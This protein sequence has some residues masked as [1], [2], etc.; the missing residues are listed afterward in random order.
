MAGCFDNINI[1][2]P[3]WLDFSEKRNAIASIIAG[4][5]FFSGWWIILDTAACYPDTKD[6]DHAYHV[7]GV[8]GTIAL[9]MINAVSNGQVRGDAYTTGCLGQR[10]A[11][12]WLLI[13]FVFGFCSLIASCWI[14][15]GS[16]VFADVPNQWPGVA[17]FLQNALIFFGTLVFKFG[18]TEDLWG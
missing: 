16:Y 11:R 17:V 15:F 6:F 10:G 7:C 2:R 14:L 18:R 5:M 13:G 3:E 4:A 12:V 9:F 1:N 8:T